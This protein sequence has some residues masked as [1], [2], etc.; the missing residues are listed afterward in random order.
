MVAP[1]L[2]AKD[3]SD[4]SFALKAAIELGYTDA[5][6]AARKEWTEHTI[7]CEQYI[8]CIAQVDSDSSPEY[9]RTLIKEPFFKMALAGHARTVSRAWCANQK[10]ALLT[11]DGLELTKELFW[12]VGK[13]N[14]MSA[15]GF[16][17]AFAQ[18]MKFD[19]SV[20]GVLIQTVKDMRN[21]LDEKKQ[22]SLYN[23]LTRV[24]S[25]FD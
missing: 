22:E 19:A 8:S 5:M 20:R 25:S 9:I 10:R 1:L 12:A 18:T 3:M 15:Y 6:A 14:Q 23:Q 4:R 21:G 7:G 24:I 17:S 2:N 16:I 13:V 11:K